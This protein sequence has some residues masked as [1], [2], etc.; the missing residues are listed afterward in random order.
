MMTVG[1][2]LGRAFPADAHRGSAAPCHDL[3]AV[4]MDR[5]ML[6]ERYGMP[7]TPVLLRDLREVGLHHDYG[8]AARCIGVSPHTVKNGLQRAYVRLGVAS[9]THAFAVLGWLRVPDR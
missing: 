8:A 2:E 7:L 3:P 1:S 9:L 6:G 5:F 4:D